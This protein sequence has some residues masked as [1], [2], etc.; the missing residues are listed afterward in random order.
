MESEDNRENASTE[1]VFLLGEIRGYMEANIGAMAVHFT[2]TLDCVQIIGGPIK[3][4]GNG[5]QKV[6]RDTTTYLMVLT[7]E[8]KMLAEVRFTDEP[9]QVLE[10]DLQPTKE[11]VS[12]LVLHPDASRIVERDMVARHKLS[13]TKFTL[14]YAEKRLEYVLQNQDTLL[15]SIKPPRSYGF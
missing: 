9:A 2:D 4:H 10:Y 12:A 1:R 5:K 3:P 14:D 15:R 7:T 13:R 8:E 11:A 6:Y